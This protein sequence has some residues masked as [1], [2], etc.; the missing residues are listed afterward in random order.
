MSQPAETTQ[1]SLGS[2][3][4][5]FRAEQL[6]HALDAF[7]ADIGGKLIYVHGCSRAFK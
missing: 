4:E 5:T 6:Q 7:N 2:A 3:Q 1:F